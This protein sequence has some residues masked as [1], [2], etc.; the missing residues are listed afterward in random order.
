MGVGMQKKSDRDH[1]V[2]I[3]GSI[4]GLLAA[5]A[6]APHFKRV[7]VLE[8]N[9]LSGNGSTRKGVPQGAHAHAMLAKGR[10]VIEEFFPGFIDEMVA[11]GAVRGDWTGDAVRY[12]GD[13]FHTRQP[14]GTS[15]MLASRALIE[16]IIRNRLASVP[17]VTLC[18]ESDVIGLITSDD[19]RRVIGVQLQR[20][21]GESHVLHADTTIDATGRG[22]RLP[23]WLR[24]LGYTPPREE[25]IEVDLVY[26][27][28]WLRR[29]P[30]QFDG[31]T[32]ITINGMLRG[33]VA[34]AQEN[35]R[36]VLSLAAYRNQGASTEE[37]GL[38]AFASTLPASNLSSLL[39]E[40]EPLTSAVSMRFPHNQRRHYE[41]LNDLPDGLLVCGDAFCSFNPLYAQGMTVA[42]M[43]ANALSKALEVRDDNLSRRY[44]RA[45]ARIIDAPWTISARN[46]AYL[47]GTNKLS[48]LTR[49]LN[50]Y[51][52]RLHIAA[53]VDVHIAETF[54]RVINLVRSPSVLFAP[55]MIWRVLRQS[56]PRAVTAAALNLNPCPNVQG[57]T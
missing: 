45:A 37:G 42:A 3:G 48:L 13:G 46:D 34:L 14:C 53:R 54:L 35:D 18:S 16:R 12:I 7:T 22:S 21:D 38:R 57:D 20:S 39:N 19:R 4:A 49:L 26:T 43:Q 6:V 28:Q 32:S 24:I 36:W 29:T 31:A 44:F 15:G 51:I 55:A 30:D 56:K 47:L 8:R 33:G 25:R 50:Y 40:A 41:R 10:L 27:T 11:L 17:N 2:V 9:H 5:R 52:A 1:A 23:A